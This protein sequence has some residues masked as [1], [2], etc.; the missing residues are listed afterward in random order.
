MFKETTGEL[1]ITDALFGPRYK[2]I[3]RIDTL[4]YYN[5]VWLENAYKSCLPE[6]TFDVL[7]SN[8]QVE[9]DW[10]IYNPYEDEINKIQPINIDAFQELTVLLVKTI[11]GLKYIKSIPLNNFKEQVYDKGYSER[12]QCYFL[13]SFPSSVYN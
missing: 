4:F 7:M 8:G 3:S 2:K 11:D 6:K 12:G 10:K 9:N 5:S 13:N 1:S